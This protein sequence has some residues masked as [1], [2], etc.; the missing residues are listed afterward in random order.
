MTETETVFE[1]QY[2]ERMKRDNELHAAGLS[3]YNAAI[4]AAATQFDCEIAYETAYDAEQARQKA[5]AL[6]AYD[7]HSEGLR[8]DEQSDER[9]D[10][11]ERAYNAA[12]ERGG[13]QDDWDAAAETAYNECALRQRQAA[14][15]EYQDNHR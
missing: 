6:T 5:A 4:D 10:A 3:A 9:A 15:Q 7:W 12:L 14:E 1:R 11:A 2:W 8:M 13:S